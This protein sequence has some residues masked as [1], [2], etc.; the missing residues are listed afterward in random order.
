MPVAWRLFRYHQLVM[1]RRDRRRQDTIDEIKDTARG[2]LASGGRAG[3]SMRAIARQLDMTASAVHYYF[4]SRQ[5]LLDALIIDGFTSLAEA[6]R[7]A[8]EEAGPRLPGE[9]WL[10]VC[11]AHRAWALDHQAEYLLLYVHDGAYSA[12][13]RNPRVD[14]AFQNVTG[15]L[16]STI[17][18]TVAAGKIDAERIEAAAPASLCRQ[19]SVWR[20]QLGGNR[21]F[22]VGALAA[23]MIVCRQLHGAIT[24]EVLGHVPPA[25]AD[26]GALF[27][28][29]MEHA[30]A[31]VCRRPFG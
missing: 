18:G 2:Q 25:L 28:L 26:R 30:Y 22:P 27:D 29:E 20:D 4:P 3:V 8:R 17:Q 16:L 21:D 9:Q 12:R 6:L 13:Q 5:A 7:T 31:S 23:C 14:Q 19:L 1:T 24:M 15:I 10:A 11:R